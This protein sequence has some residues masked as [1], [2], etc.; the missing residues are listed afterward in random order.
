M[1]VRMIFIH[2]KLTSIAM[3]FIIFFTFTILIFISF[4][5][6]QHVYENMVKA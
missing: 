6:K 5:I 1:N 2:L 3:F 4:L